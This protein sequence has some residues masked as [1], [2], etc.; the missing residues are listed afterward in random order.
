M[1]SSALTGIL[2]EKRRRLLRQWSRHGADVSGTSSV[3]GNVRWRH[4]TDLW[5][6][7][8]LITASAAAG[9]PG[10]LAF[11]RRAV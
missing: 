4:H 3:S 10:E 7:E 11:V 8:S 2:R 9:S 1:T 5:E 6:I